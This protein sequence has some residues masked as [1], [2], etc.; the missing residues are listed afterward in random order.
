MILDEYIDVGITWK[1][2]Q[3]YE[4]LGYII[5]TVYDDI[6]KKNV[7]KKGT[8][9]RI[10]V[11]ELSENSHEKIH[12]K[13]DYCGKDY[14]ITYQSYC[15]Y[16][17]KYGD[18]ACSECKGEHGKITFNRLYNVDNISQ[19]EEIKNKKKQKSLE[20]YGTE[21]VLQA[22]EVREK[23]VK[24]NMDKYGVPIPTQN[25]EI[26]EKAKKTIEE[27]YGSIDEYNRIRTSKAQITNQNKYGVAVASKSE[28]VIQKIKDTNQIK[29]GHNS[30]MGNQEIQEKAMKTT[31]LHF[32]VDSPAKSQEIKE[33]TKQTMIERFGCE[34]PMQSDEILNKARKTLLD[35]GNI[36][37]STQQK[38]IHKL[39]GGFLNYPFQRYNLDIFNEDKQIAVEYSG[40]G[41]DL[42]V[43]LGGI[44]QEEFDKKELIRKSYIKRAGIKLIEIV[45]PHDLIP[46]DEV[47]LKMYSFAEEYFNTT[48]HTWISFY[49]EENT[50]KNAL[51]GETEGFFFD[52]GE[53]RKIK[54]KGVK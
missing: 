41:H 35:N 20:K 52:F 27:K 3:K 24:T 32:G 50:Y 26:K 40:G 5:P 33:K 42:S 37:T 28:S 2:K 8:K 12:A 23:I 14:Y 44:T 21:Y 51:S 46:S 19:L 30:P 47:L 34:Y 45:T 29:Y 11:S 18:Y 15:K 48:N 4:D 22:D 9:I 31:M 25:D 17:K 7:V 43:K 38:Y 1:N 36:E 16:I 39:Y 49:T 53:L 54:N 13:C 6:H 10:K